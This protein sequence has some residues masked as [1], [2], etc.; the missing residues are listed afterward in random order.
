MAKKIKK[1]F[2]ETG[3][4]IDGTFLTSE[5]ANQRGRENPE[6]I[7]KFRKAVRR[8]GK[9]TSCRERNLSVDRGLSLP[10]GSR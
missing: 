5:E 7:T 6:L 1:V 9:F 10:S 2:D 8:D 3:Y 4:E